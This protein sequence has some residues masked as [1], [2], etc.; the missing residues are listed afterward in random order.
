MT[1]SFSSTG[2]DL[3]RSGTRS[4]TRNELPL[5]ATILVAVENKDS[6]EK[7]FSYAKQIGIGAI[8][9]ENGL[10]AVHRA[11]D[12]CYE[13]VLLD[14]KMPVMD[15]HTA[16]RILR[17]KGYK[18]TILALM[19]DDLQEN[20]R[21]CMETGCNDYL[22][23]PLEQEQFNAMI[24]RYLAIGTNSSGTLEPI[25]SELLAEGHAFDE[26][27]QTFASRLPAALEDIRSAFRELDW[28]SLKK[29]VHDLKGVSGNMGYPKIA[30]L[31]KDIESAITKQDTEEISRALD[32][33]SR[34]CD[35]IRLGAGLS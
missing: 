20:I 29:K 1:T 21:K 25:K 2:S 19:E 24:T 11:L 16:M 10:D 33:M 34:V 22:V 6:Q 23:K 3:D 26:L 35:Q 5:A 31:S 28:D 7:I 4:A 14:L 8:A 27:I 13:I 32:E 9:A 30:S 17:D 15:G 12:G 18:R